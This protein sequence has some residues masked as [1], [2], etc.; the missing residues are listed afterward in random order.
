MKKFIAMVFSFLLLIGL[1]ACNG[2]A[3]ENP[4][5]A[6]NLKEHFFDLAREYRLDYVY[7]EE[8]QEYDETDNEVIKWYAFYL[9][10]Y[11]ESMTEEYI[12][13]V[14]QKYYGW[15]I[16]LKGD[17]SLGA[18]SYSTK[19]YMGLT[20]YKSEMIDGK[21][22]NTITMDCYQFPGTG[23]NPEDYQPDLE[24]RPYEE[25]EGAVYEVMEAEGLSFLEAARKMISEG[26]TENFQVY[27]RRTICYEAD[28]ED[29]PL[30]FLWVE[31]EN[32]GLEDPENSE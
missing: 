14:A 6:G 29:R 16:D 11:P 22:I 2:D 30:R 31:V 19:A 25:E 13:E 8:G 18:E 12:E 28:P 20:S 3:E 27:K 32:I 17:T 26:N 15:D 24:Y 5:D 10:N 9:A 21:K 4:V 1:A 7:I 23:F